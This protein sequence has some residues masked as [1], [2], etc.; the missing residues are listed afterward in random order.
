MPAENSRFLIVLV[1]NLT[2]Y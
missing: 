2:H 1:N